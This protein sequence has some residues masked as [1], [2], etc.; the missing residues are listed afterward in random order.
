MRHTLTLMMTIVFLWVSGDAHAAACDLLFPSCD[1]CFQGPSANKRW[2][3]P[4]HSCQGWCIAAVQGQADKAVEALG[5]EHAS[6]KGDTV[7]IHPQKVESAPAVEMDIRAVRELAAVNPG[8]AVAL[9]MFRSDFQSESP[10]NMLRG[11][12]AWRGTPTLQTFE[13]ML[14]REDAQATE[15]SLEP[16]EPGLFHQIR[17]NGVEIDGDMLQVIFFSEII[18]ESMDVKRVT[19]PETV[20]LVSKTPPR[21]LSISYQ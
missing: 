19:H 9:L 10:S 1:P 20:V 6:A 8:A 15:D 14:E 11:A 17:W 16:L 7:Y 12:A 2:G 5:P 3:G 21:V 13:L 18:D 4:C